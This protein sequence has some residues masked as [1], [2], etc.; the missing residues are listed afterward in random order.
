[1]MKY[2]ICLLMGCLPSLLGAQTTDIPSADEAT[3]ADT[4]CATF[5][6]DL[7][8][9]PV[10]AP[11]DIYGI[12]PLSYS[13]AAWELHPGM[14]AQI[15]MSLTFSPS[16]WMPSGVGFGQDVAFL[17]AAPLT[18]R[19]SVAG[20]V[21]ASNLNWGRIGYRNVGLAAIAA[22]R[23]NDRI[24]LYAYGNKSLTPQHASPFYV[25]LPQFNADRIGGMVNFKVGESASI[26]IGFEGTRYPVGYR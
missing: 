22:Y 18:S 24:S 4:L 11:F 8:T 7:L 1:M 23:L 19:L 14:N 5:R 17:Y 15:G 9:A 3:Q 16:S 12:T 25:P 26:G 6:G 21:Y 2:I 20:G 13:Y 10:P